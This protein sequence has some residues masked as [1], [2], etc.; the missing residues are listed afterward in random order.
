MST[1]PLSALL[2]GL[3]STGHCLAMCGGL[4]VAAGQTNRRQLNASVSQRGIVLAGWQLGRVLSYTLM[5][6]MVGAFGA[7]FLAQAPVVIIRQTAF[8]M[9]NLMLIALG[10][11]VAQLWSGIV[12][13]ERI[14]QIVWRWVQPLATATLAPQT[15]SY[16]QPV[17]ET[18]RAMRAGAI[19]GWLPCGLVYSMLVTASV[20]G[21]AASGALWML[22]FGL[23]TMPAL[24]MTSMASNR[25]TDQFRKPVVRKSAG[26]LIIA[27][28][29]WG[30]LRA[31]G[32]I[33]VDWFDAFCIGGG[34]FS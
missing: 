23:G 22:A 3:W 5:G 20:S 29:L 7:F 16:P 11:H 2:I 27:F 24:W 12:Q 17:K 9:A 10:L 28:G 1:F 21:S 32:L 4:A 13:L 18:L 31:T 34:T 15:P 25:L 6:L 8:V 19:W 14:G 26:L 30:L 33:Q